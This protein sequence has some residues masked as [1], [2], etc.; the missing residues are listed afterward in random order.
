MP[1]AR[2]C[3]QLAHFEDWHPASEDRIYQL[4][5][6]A[7]S[8]RMKLMFFGNCTGLVGIHA[9]RSRH[10]SIRK[11]ELP[12][13]SQ[14]FQTRADVDMYLHLQRCRERFEQGQAPGF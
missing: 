14:A 13:S 6:S 11:V 4:R 7:L 8:E 3:R 2:N 9:G 10:L 5:I 1:F 12:P